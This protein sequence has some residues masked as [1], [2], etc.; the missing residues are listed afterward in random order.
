MFVL[1]S[2]EGR[3]RGTIT[4]AVTLLVAVATVA[5]WTIRNYRVLDAFVPVS[6]NGGSVFYL[7]NNPLATGGYTEAGERDLA[8]LLADE[9]A[10]NQTGITWGIEWIRQHPGDFA[11]LAVQ[12]QAI[13][14]GSDDHWLY[15]AVARGLGYTGPWYRRCQVGRERM[16]GDIARADRRGWCAGAR[17]SRG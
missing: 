10:W 9:V 11:R 1:L 16:V 6:T 15:W 8:A 14:T 5:P 13:L 4:A 12:K 2:R 7:A 17:G 3:R